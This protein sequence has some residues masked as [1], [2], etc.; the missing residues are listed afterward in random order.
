MCPLTLVF[1]HLLGCGQFIL[2]EIPTRDVGGV[3]V[4]DLPQDAVVVDARTPEEWAAGHVP[5]AA[6]VHWTELTGFDED[7]LWDA[8]PVEDKAALL[9][10]R[11]VPSDQPLVLY[12]SGPE[13]WG[14]DGNLYWALRRLGHPQ[15]QVLDGGYLGWLAGGGAPTTARDAPPA[16]A[17][18]V[19]EDPSVYADSELVSMWDGVLLDVR[20]EEEWA[21]GRVPGAVWM[22]WDGVFSADGTLLPEDE[23]WALFGEAG[24]DA[25]TPVTTYCA[26]GIRAGH[27][28]M[29]LEALGAVEVRNYV[30]SWARWIGEGRPVER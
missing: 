6:N 3:I 27:T 7:E 15:V 26:A 13:G 16:A 14:D 20:S 11:G 9:A 19:D 8:I 29:V 17:F 4:A 10:A 2:G 24:I 5:G 21:E 28:F 25:D 1:L 18:T 30:G 22:P 23:L 12:G